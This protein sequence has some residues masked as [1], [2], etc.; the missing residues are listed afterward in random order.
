MA[1]RRTPAEIARDRAA[2]LA[3][4]R[5]AAAEGGYPWVRVAE[6]NWRPN[7]VAALVASGEV[8]RRVRREWDEQRFRRGSDSG[9]FGGAGAVQRHRAYVA[10][11]SAVAE[12]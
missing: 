8:A 5:E 7:D 3:A 6:Q 9:L 2:I 1:A 4:L 12:A 11:A 10:L